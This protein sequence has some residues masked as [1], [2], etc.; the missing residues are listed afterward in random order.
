MVGIKKGSQ[1]RIKSDFGLT[2]RLVIWTWTNYISYEQLTW[3]CDLAEDTVADSPKSEEDD[4]V[5][6][7]L[8]SLATGGTQGLD[9]AAARGR[10]GE[11]GLLSV[12]FCSA[13]RPVP[14]VNTA[15]IIDIWRSLGHHCVMRHF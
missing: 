12:M 13:A 2:S 7:E 1:V 3:K 8:T 14:C 4:S 11:G 5:C 10:H 6:E 9:A 15:A